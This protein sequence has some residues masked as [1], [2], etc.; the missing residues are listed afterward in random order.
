MQWLYAGKIFVQTKDSDGLPEFGPLA[1]LYVLGEKLLDDA[2]QD[3]VLD[4]IICLTRKEVEGVKYFPGNDEINIIYKGT[5]RS[6]PA[7]RLLVDAFT[8]DGK[9]NWMEEGEEFWPVPEQFKDDLLKS[10]LKGRKI[11]DKRRRTLKEID[12]G[13]PCVYHKHGQDKP[14]GSMGK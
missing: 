12:E 13:V 3:R 6:S 4:V 5:G 9:E 11:T 7:R 1:K 2:F 8:L 14:C 10:M